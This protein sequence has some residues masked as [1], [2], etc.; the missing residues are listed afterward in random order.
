MLNRPT[1]TMD[2]EQAKFI[3]SAYRPGGQDAEDPQFRE[4]LEQVQ[5][6]PDLARWFEEHRAED[7]RI[8]GKLRSAPVPPDLKQTILAAK[9]VVTPSV[10]RRRSATLAWAACLALLLGLGGLWFRAHTGYAAFHKDMVQAVI[11]LDSL[12]YRE[13]DLARIDEWLD[14]GPAPSDF[15][16]PPKLSA[17]TG[18]GCRVLEWKGAK[19]T[20]ICLNDDSKGLRDKV[21]L[22][23]IDADKIPGSLPGPKPRFEENGSIATAAWSDGEHAYILAGHRGTRYL[24][25]YF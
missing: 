21:H 2:N 12:D 14:Q 4:A 3:L 20:L 8:A 7:A 10:W 22:L 9:V 6:D 11:D 19:V 17:L 25:G 15:E 18:L 1:D 5:H 13:S 24:A 16:M 23:V